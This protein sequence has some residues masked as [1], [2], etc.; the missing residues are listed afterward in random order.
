MQ[1]GH[2]EPR[3]DIDR[4]CALPDFRRLLLASL[5]LIA[6]AGAASATDPDDLD[7]FLPTTLEDA[8]TGDPK[9]GEAQVG[10]RFDRRRGH[11]ELQIFPQFQA[12]PTNGLLLNLSLP[13][14]VGSGD[15][16]N[17]GEISAG[18]LY[19]FN[20]ETR[21]LPAFAVAV[22]ASTPIGPG[23][24]GTQLQLTGV[25]SR[26]I[27]PAGNKRL[28]L[29]ASWIT[30]FAPSQDERHNR[31]R[32]V[33]GYSQLLDRDTAIIVDYVRERQEFG[34]RDANIVE[35]GFRHRLGERVTIGLGGG[36]GLGR[37]SPKY[38]LLF[39]LE[40]DL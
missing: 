39:S 18:A 33:A 21:W 20:R 25:A 34:E 10:L 19:N 23:D 37:D 16:A 13:Y 31:Y 32:V 22:D 6:A 3:H 17:Q 38:R 4:A 2:N 27:D 40:M 30:R 36:A 15:R 29:N 26:T 28:H 14:V 1:R 8:F 35:V 7:I 9:A 12:S 24:R 11:D 5:G